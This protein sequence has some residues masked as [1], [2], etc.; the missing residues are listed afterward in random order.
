MF[1][2]IV[3]VI[4]NL[5]ACGSRELSTEPTVYYMIY[6]RMDTG[7]CRI[8]GIDKNGNP[9]VIHNINAADIT[10]SAVVGD[11][12]VAG[13]HRRNNHLLMQQDGSYKEFYLLDDPG[14]SGVWGITLDGENI[15]SV[16]NGN[17]DNEN[18][19]YLNLLVIQDRNQNVLVKKEIDI[20]PSTMLIEGDWLYMAGCYWQ[21]DAEP[22]YCGN[23]VARYHL[24]T[25]EYE[26][27]H[28]PY[29]ADEMTAVDYRTM[30]KHGNY[31]YC[32]CAE[33]LTDKDMMTRQNRVDI[34][35]SETLELMDTQVF[36]GQIGKICFVGD[37]L[38]MTIAGKLNQVDTQTYETEEL[39]D[40]PQNTAVEGCQMRNGHL[41]FLARFLPAQK[42]EKLW[43]I[44]YMID[45]NT[46]DNGVVQ[47][48]LMTDA[49]NA[50]NVVFFPLGE[51]DK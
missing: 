8:E 35:N 51:I 41:Y 38:Y 50:E 1:V 4:F 43:N 9:T 31:L 37:E 32:V 10:K 2:L 15:V 26:E 44:G 12:F 27:K 19:V 25:G 40:F 29:D 49:K 21:Y 6:S 42:E 20:T 28:F 45:Y 13:G 14:Y 11:E 17:V 34:I 30:T 16:M 48:P 39:Y 3:A 7:K 47:I 33:S 22:I 18:G 23:S 46:A 24:K 5:T 36:D